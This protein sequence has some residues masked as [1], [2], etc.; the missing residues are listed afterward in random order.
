MNTNQNTNTSTEGFKD[1]SVRSIGFGLAA[2]AVLAIGFGGW[3][4]TARMSGAVVT[5][6]NVV[7]SSD[8]RTVQHPDGGIV[9]DIHV[10]N[11]DRVQAGD[12]VLRLDDQLLSG[13]QALVDDRL[14][15]IEAQLARLTAE[16]DGLDDLVLSDELVSRQDE[17]K[18]QRALT[19]QKAVMDARRLSQDGEVAALTEQI[20]QIEQEITGLE[21]QRAAADEEITLIESEL[22]GQKHLLEKGLTPETRVIALKRQRSGL[23]GNSGGLISRIAVARGRISETRINILQLEK[24][25]RE[26]IMNEISTLEVELDGLKERRSAAELQLSRVDLRAPADGIVHEM[27]VNTVGG[28]VSPGETLMQIV[29]EGDGLVV[30]ASVMPQDINNVAVGQ[31]ANVVIA[32]FDHHIAPRL[33]GRV[34][35]VSADLKTDP[36]TGMQYYE[37]R[38]ALEDDAFAL[39]EE[40]QLNLLPGMPAEVYIATGERTLIEYLIDPLSKQ[41]RTTFREA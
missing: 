38:V 13:S 23:V 22:V 41:I 18:V 5:A 28:V 19:T 33:D 17:V 39:L 1:R 36:M 21:A 8:L 14:V 35:F 30:T 7:V 4:T 2:I 16:R 40:R 26:Q 24:T 12:V 6:G 9:G 25:F 27:M 10:R 34:E 3:A 29:P 31:S 20:T 11:G 15:A 32:A 37:A